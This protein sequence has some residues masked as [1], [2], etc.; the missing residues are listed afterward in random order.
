MWPGQGSAGRPY[1]VTSFDPR[2]LAQIGWVL[3]TLSL[4]VPDTEL[5]SIGVMAFP[6]SVFYG[7]GFLGAIFEGLW[8]MALVGLALLVGAAINVSL[9]VWTP[10]WFS[11]IAPFLALAP[12][13]AALFVSHTPSSA[14]GMLF[15][16]PWAAGITLIHLARVRTSPYPPRPEGNRE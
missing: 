3:W 15:F 1:T 16:Y 6:I 12:F 13:V 4:V 8:S 14:L 5:S 11:L 2:R 10:R 7:I 9:F